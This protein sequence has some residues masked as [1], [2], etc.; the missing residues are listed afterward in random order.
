MLEQSDTEKKHRENV[1]KHI[2]LF[3]GLFRCEKKYA[4]RYLKEWSLCLI[5][6][7]C[8]LRTFHALTTKKTVF[9]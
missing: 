5:I 3:G 8:E 1:G 9:I 6:Y 2:P 4:L 7:F